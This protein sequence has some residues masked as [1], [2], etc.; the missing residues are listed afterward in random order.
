MTDL[1]TLGGANSFALGINNRGQVV[2]SSDTAS[3]DTHAFLWEDGEMTDL[4]HLGGSSSVATGINNRGQVVGQSAT[5]AGYNHAVLWSK[6]G[7]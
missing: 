1:G 2:G 7:R 4:G 3:G 5:F 6:E